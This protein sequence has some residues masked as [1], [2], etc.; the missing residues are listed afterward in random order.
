MKK[1]RIF[2]ASLLIAVSATGCS[3]T[4]VKPTME[5]VVESTQV[6]S[7]VTTVTSVEEATTV[8]D[9]E[10]ATIVMDVEEADVSETL[11]E[12]LIDESRHEEST[13]Y[14]IPEESEAVIYDGETALY[15]IRQKPDEAYEDGS[16]NLVVYLLNNDGTSEMC[17]TYSGFSVNIASYDE[18]DFLVIRESDNPGNVFLATVLGLSDG[19]FKEYATPQS[20]S[21]KDEVCMTIVAENKAIVGRVIFGNTISDNG[22]APFNYDSA[23]D[24]FVEGSIEDITIETLR[25]YDTSGIVNYE[26]IVSVKQRGDFVVHVNYADYSITYILDNNALVE[27]SADYENLGIYPDIVY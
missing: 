26:G 19:V 20:D 14:S 8:M 2:V 23:S 11:T 9:V 21:V 5:S 17:A 10:E 22:I 4:V 15:V 1:I 25:V 6:T 7:E 16:D 18:K 3:N 24:T 12:S 27:Y 13:G